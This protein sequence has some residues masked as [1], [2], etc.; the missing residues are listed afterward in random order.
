MR[1]FTFCAW[2]CKRS[3][4]LLL[5]ENNEDGEEDVVDESGKGENDGVEKTIEKI[6]KE[7]L[8]RGCSFARRVSAAS[9]VVT[10]SSAAK[11]EKRTKSFCGGY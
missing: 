4:K 1:I 5:I 11:K 9:A 10:S 3:R 8:V 7:N 6:G 2:R